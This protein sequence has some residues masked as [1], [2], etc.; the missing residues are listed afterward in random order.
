MLTKRRTNGKSA[1]VGIA[2]VL[3]L[4]GASLC[5]ADAEHDSAESNIDWAAGGIRIEYDNDLLVN[6]DNKF[7]NGLSLQWH[8]RLAESWEDVKVPKWLKFGQY[9][10]GMK[11]PQLYN[12]IGLAIGQNMQTPNDLAATELI[13]DDV[14]YAGSLGL[15][16]NWIAFD[17]DSFRGY[18]LIA[19]VIGPAS[20]AESTQKAIHS[21]IGSDEPMG[22]DNQIPNEFALNTYGMFK[23]KIFKSESRG[24]FS[25]DLALNAD[26]GLGTALTFGEVA[27]EAR[28][29]WNVPYGFAFLPDPIGRSIAYD[30]TIP[31][32]QD[33][34]TSFYFSFIHRR[35]YIQHFVFLDGSLWRDTHSVDYDRWQQQTIIGVHLAR[36]RWGVH[37]SFWDSSA[38]VRTSL[39][40][41]GNDF[42]T[43]AFEWRF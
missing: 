1:A 28:A 35:T 29:G 31:H 14:P 22:W 19:G 23:R 9:L 25:T 6:S 34:H 3:C 37:L 32:Q 4:I 8:S 24:H 10:P 21:V 12:R 30:A 43:I 15:E 7:T 18:G 27:L 39:A 38:N 11:A 13:V 5:F 36:R 40:G 16:L 17:D 33:G 41:H 26:F 20:G 42:G 2:P